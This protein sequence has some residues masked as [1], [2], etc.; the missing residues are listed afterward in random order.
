MIKVMRHVRL[1]DF[2][3]GMV[4]DA[5]FV[6]FV[7]DVFAWILEHGP[8]IQS[9]GWIGTDGCGRGQVVHEFDGERL[10]GCDFECGACDGGTG[11]VGVGS[12]AVDV[13]FVSY[14]EFGGA[15]GCGED[16]IHVTAVAGLGTW[17][18]VR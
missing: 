12:A 17:D 1:I 13:A 9:G 7:F 4:L 2:E 5:F 16:V 8:V 18:V 3:I 6:A 15:D 14:L 11:G 10:T